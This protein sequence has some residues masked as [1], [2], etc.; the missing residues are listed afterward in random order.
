MP[1]VVFKHKFKRF[2][3]IIYQNRKAGNLR[4]RPISFSVV[5]EVMFFRKQNNRSETILLIG[6]QRLANFLS[7]F[8][9]IFLGLTLF[10]RLSIEY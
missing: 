2:T 3:Y 10:S 4:G 1:E 7:V 8:L 9:K 6:D 5:V